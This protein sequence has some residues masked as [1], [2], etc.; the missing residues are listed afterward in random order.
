MIKTAKIMNDKDF[1]AWVRRQLGYPLVKVELTDDQIKDNIYRA[2]DMFIKYAS[3]NGSEEAFYSLMLSAGQ[4]DYELPEGILDVIDFNDEG[5]G[6][7]GINTLFTMQ[8]QLY[9]AGLLN[10][11]D[12]GTGLTMVSYHLALDFIEVIQRYTTTGFQWNYD[13]VERILTVSPE[14]ESGTITIHEPNTGSSKIVNSPGWI[15]L[16]VKQLIGTG[17]P[18]FSSNKAYSA[19]YNKTW[20]KEYTLALCK[21]VL[22]EIRRKFESYSSIGNTGIALNGDAL[23]SE[24]KEEKEQLEEKLMTFENYSGY[25]ILTGIV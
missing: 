7:H 8:N 15:L 21:I 25:G 17:R 1:C 24:G 13:D 22:G 23:L 11:G 12:L 2:L 14:P 5:Y 6:D 4:T 19:L 20:V 3:D 10:F 16:K 18:G 9:N